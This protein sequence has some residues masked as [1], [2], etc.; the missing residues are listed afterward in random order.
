MNSAQTANSLDTYFSCLS[1]MYEEIETV[2][3]M[4]SASSNDESC[5]ETS[6]PP[7]TVPPPTLTHL[8]KFWDCL[9]ETTTKIAVRN[10]VLA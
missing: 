7:P 2:V 9:S 5:K 10:Q 1:I 8:A 4:I 6:A 3:F